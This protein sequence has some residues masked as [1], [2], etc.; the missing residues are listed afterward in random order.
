[1]DINERHIHM[2]PKY[3]QNLISILSRRFSLTN[4]VIW[5]WLVMRRMMGPCQPLMPILS[6]FIDCLIYYQSSQS[7]IIY[8]FVVENLMLFSS[9]GPSTVRVWKWK[10]YEQFMTKPI[11]KLLTIQGKENRQNKVKSDIITYKISVHNCITR[12]HN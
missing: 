4:G 8:H 10:E 11:S 9:P 1:M 6:I 2:A 7:N 12:Q 5:S 3:E